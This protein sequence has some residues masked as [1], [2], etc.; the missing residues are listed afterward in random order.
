MEQL[1]DRVWK[2]SKHQLA[3]FSLIIANLIWGSAS[4]IFKWSLQGIEPFTLGFFRFFLG[5][6]LLLPLTLH[7]LR[8]HYRHWPKLILL[9]LTGITIHISLFFLGLKLTA[10]VNAPIIASS[11]PIFIIIGSM[12]FLHEQPLPRVL[13]GTGISLLG[14]L[15]IVFQPLFEQGMDT[16]IFGNFLLVTATVGTVLHT[17]LLRNLA[18]HYAAL[19][20]TFWSFVIGSLGFLPFF[21]LET[22]QSEF[23]NTLTIQGFVGILFGALFASALAYYLYNLALKYVK[24]SEAGI[25]VYMDPIVAILIA[26]PLLGEKITPIFILGSLLVFAGIYIAER[27]INYHPFNKLRR[28]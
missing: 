11:A 8:V 9:S 24:A 18:K 16:S 6:L 21:L 17:L 25:F 23:L 22:K 5:A 19:T 20:L 1:N 7:E 13:I 2:L 26:I 28:I 3:V 15:L 4:P 12:I 14:I 27:R 10:S